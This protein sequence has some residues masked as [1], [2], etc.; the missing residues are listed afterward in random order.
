MVPVLSD[1]S[2]Q[3]IASS[4]SSI[5]MG[6]RTNS[7]SPRY[8]IDTDTH[9]DIILILYVFV[10]SGVSLGTPTF[11]VICDIGSGAGFTMLAVARNAEQ[12][13]A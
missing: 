6:L 8:G 13:F 10:L 2:T 1:Y 9:K 3:S 7:S 12:T 11:L 4:Q 5:S